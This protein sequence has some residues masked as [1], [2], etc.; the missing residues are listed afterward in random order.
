MS[1]KL[2]YFW[3]GSAITLLVLV[4][5]ASLL[6]PENIPSGNDKVQHFVSYA[7]L[8][9]WWFLVFQKRYIKE[10]VF[11]AI[12]LVLFGGLVEILQGMTGYRFADINDALANS[13]GILFATLFLPLLFHEVLSVLDRKMAVK[14]NT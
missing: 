4:L 9:S 14:F 10:R 13:M 3:R 11:I 5:V 8:A 7:V 12:S 2:K 6:P 1:L